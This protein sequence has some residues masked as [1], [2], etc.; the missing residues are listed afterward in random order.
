MTAS[1]VRSVRPL[2]PFWVKYTLLNNLQDFL[3]VRLI[4]NSEGELDT[5]ITIGWS[6]LERKHAGPAII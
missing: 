5:L 6:S 1:C 3:A 2:E 4:W